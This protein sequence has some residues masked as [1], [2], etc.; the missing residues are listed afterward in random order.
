M[1]LT[2]QQLEADVKFLCK[3]ARLAGSWRSDKK[4][5][6][7]ISSNAIVT[8][9]YGG[10]WPRRLGME[11]QMP[12]DQY[13]LAACERAVKL[14]PKHRRTPKVMKA[15]QNARDFLAEKEL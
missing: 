7:G 14:L 6:W 8:L 9:A 13:D 15:L 1:N 3:R 4:R 11:C 10:P 2:K 5:S 12:G